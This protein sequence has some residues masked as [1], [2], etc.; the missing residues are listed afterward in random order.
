MK[1]TMAWERVPT[2]SKRPFEPGWRDSRELPLGK[3]SSKN[4]FRD[5]GEVESFRFLTRKEMMA[6]RGIQSL[7]STTATLE[8]AV[9]PP[10]VANLPKHGSTPR[11]YIAGKGLAPPP[12]GHRLP[13]PPSPF[14]KSKNTVASTRSKSSSK[15]GWSPETSFGTNDIEAGTLVPP[16]PSVFGFS[17]GSTKLAT[18][19][20]AEPSLPPVPAHAPAAQTGAH[21]TLLPQRVQASN[22][23]SPSPTLHAPAPF[24]APTP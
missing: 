19:A 7:R 2:T 21:A 3:M 10:P 4:E 24:L 1:K 11:S 13:A 22:A 15:G 17:F 23:P 16:P 6:A 8:E 5:E 20:A 14:S 9:L 18:Q 12:R